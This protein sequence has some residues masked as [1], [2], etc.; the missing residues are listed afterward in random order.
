MAN[1]V[2]FG[3]SAATARSFAREVDVVYVYATQ[4]TPAL[5]PWLW[6]LTGGAPYVLHVQ[7]LWPDSITGSSLVKG[8]LGARVVDAALTLGSPSVYRHAAA[9]IG[10]APTMVETLIKRGV[11][12]RKAHLVYN[13]ADEPD[14]RGK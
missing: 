10:I 9:V 12:R 1:Y 8:G 13:W 5:G 14:S 3:L 4:M 6:R 11:D 7:D 2:S